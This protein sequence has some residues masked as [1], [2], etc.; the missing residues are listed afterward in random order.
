MVRPERLELPA[1][2]FEAS[3][4]IQ[5]SYGRASQRDFR[6]EFNTLPGYPDRVRNSSSKKAPENE[7]KIGADAEE[8]RSRLRSQGFRVVRPRV[9]EQNIVLDDAAASLR[10]RNLLLRVRTAGKIITCT[11]KG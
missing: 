5:L 7:I 3:R 2:W 11:F 4:S 6:N 8:I 10:G 1:Y 9:F